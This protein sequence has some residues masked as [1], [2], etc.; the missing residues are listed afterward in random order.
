MGAWANYQQEA[1]LKD[2]MEAPPVAATPGCFLL[3]PNWPNDT[4][5]PV[6][7]W[8]IGAMWTVPVTPFGYGDGEEAYVLHPDG[9]VFRHFPVWGGFIP[10]CWGNL[11]EWQ[12]W[13]AKHYR[14]PSPTTGSNCPFD[15]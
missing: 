1:A 2:A 11:E 13:V 5:H 4:P 9:R 7:A 3:N 14:S 12:S 6:I 10:D 15:D 8:K